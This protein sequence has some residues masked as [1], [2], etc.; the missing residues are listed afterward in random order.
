MQRLDKQLTD[1]ERKNFE[2]KAGG[3][4]IAQ[5]ARELLNAYDPDTHEK[6]QDQVE[7][8]MAGSPPE[9]K[10][11]KCDKQI[12]ALADSA[13]RV[14]TGELNKYIEDLRK[15]HEQII[16]E[17]N[18]DTLIHAGWDTNQRDRAQAM[19]REFGEWAED[20]VT[21]LEIFYGQPFRRRELTY[22]GQE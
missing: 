17:H 3:K 15:I 6:I 11:A 20:Q 5:V 7:R 13:A 2:Q 12:S 10:Q 4:A 22:A 19:I 21:A 8:D 18:L 14:F 1:K 9:E 16:D